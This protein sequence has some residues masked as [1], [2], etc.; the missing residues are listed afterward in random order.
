MHSPKEQFGDGCKI[1][2]IGLVPEH[3]SDDCHMRVIVPFIAIWSNVRELPVSIVGQLGE[4][5]FIRHDAV[6]KA[7]VIW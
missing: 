2:E 4:L 6:V 1:F 5:T 7:L 3:F